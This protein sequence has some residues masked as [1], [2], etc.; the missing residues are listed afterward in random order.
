MKNDVNRSFCIATK[1][2]GAKKWPKGDTLG[3]LSVS[4]EIKGLS[5]SLEI[6]VLN[7]TKNK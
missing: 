7:I 3:G 4:L 6:K 5:V 1:N 2:D